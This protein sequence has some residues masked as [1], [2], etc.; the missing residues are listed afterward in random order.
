MSLE[1]THDYPTRNKH[2]P[3]NAKACNIKYRKC[4]IYSAFSEYNTLSTDIKNSK[5]LI[6]FVRRSK[7][8]LMT[9]LPS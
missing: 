8:H 6:E 7:E 9:A 3:N 5:H 2:I 4:I 1:K